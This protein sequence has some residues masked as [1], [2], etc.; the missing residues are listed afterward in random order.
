[1]SHDILLGTDSWHRFPSR[2]YTDVGGDTCLL[3]LTTAVVQVPL[4]TSD[5]LSSPSR[6]PKMVAAVGRSD[7]SPCPEM[8][9][10]VECPDH[11]G[12]EFKLVFNCKRPRQF[13]ADSRVWVP[14]RVETARGEVVSSG[15]FYARLAEIWDPHEIVVEAGGCELPLSVAQNVQ[16]HPD[17]VISSSLTPL[18]ETPLSDFV[19][20]EISESGG[21][22]NGLP[23][24]PAAASS[25][26]VVDSTPPSVDAPPDNPDRPEQPP[27][28][29]LA[30]MSPEC[31][32]A[33]RRL[34]SAVPPHLRELNLV[35]IMQRG[36]P[37]I[38]ITSPRCWCNIPIGFP[39]VRWTWG[40]VLPFHSVSI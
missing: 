14:L 8:V 25:V 39:K 10:M 22:E 33:F 3:R 17:E 12:S 29:I 16:L 6:S 15:K 24:P 11:D 37:R 34:W 7:P 31:Q 23:T 13:Q 4:T 36:P 40:I 18:I 9:A 32:V 21:D 26:N 38:S 5:L 1:M 35:S 28:E 19:F 2:E 20:T 27:P 30:G